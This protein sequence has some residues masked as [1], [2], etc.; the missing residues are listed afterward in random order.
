MAYFVL[1]VLLRIYSLTDSL[2]LAY[3]AD[4]IWHLRC[5]LL[6]PTALA[7]LCLWS[8]GSKFPVAS[9]MCTIGN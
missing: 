4:Y 1:M 7:P 8:A 3:G 5:S 6:V 9:Q 2:T